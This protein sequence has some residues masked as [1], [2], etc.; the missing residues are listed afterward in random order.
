M[1]RSRSIFRPGPALIRHL[2]L[3]TLAAVLAVAGC[4]GGKPAGPAALVL[5]DQAG[6]TQAKINAAGALK[7]APFAYSWASFPGASPLFEALAA[8]AVDTAP[9]GDT[10]VIAAAAARAPIRIVAATRSS[11]AGVAILVPSDS[12]IR[13]VADLRGHEVIVSSARGSVAQYLLLGALR[14]AGVDPA[15]VTIGFMP[16]NDAAAAFGAGRI[17]AWATFGIYQATAESR[18]A[19]IVRDGRGINSGLGFLAVA[20]A[21]L[22]DPAKRQAIIAYVARLRRANDWSRAHPD[23]YAAVYARQTG[24]PLSIAKVMVA[25]ENPSLVAPDAAIARELQ[26]V[27]DRFHREGVLPASVDVAPLVDATIFAAAAKQP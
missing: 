23:A 11:G 5:G 24:V 17:E 22:D 19:R 15:Q 27:A 3:A 14:E 9:A 21:A 13:T 6:L 1:A 18:G 8:G 10:P 20:Q 16:P 7:D 4:G 26:T 12:A 2:R 25:R